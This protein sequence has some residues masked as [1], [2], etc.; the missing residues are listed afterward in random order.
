MQPP[1]TVKQQYWFDHISA[2]QLND[3]PLSAYAAAHQLNIKAL[4]NWRWTFSKS[5]MKAPTKQTSFVKVLPPSNTTASIKSPI[6]ATLP[7]GI[8]LQFDTLTPDM[9]ALLQSC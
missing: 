4:Y 6:I 1:L 3:Q 2:A 9:L 8:R 7:N 5:G